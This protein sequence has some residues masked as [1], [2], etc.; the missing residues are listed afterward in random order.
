M[1]TYRLRMVRFD[2]PETRILTISSQNE[3]TARA[4]ALARFGHGWRVASTQLAQFL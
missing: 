3:S 1:K 2:R 4:H